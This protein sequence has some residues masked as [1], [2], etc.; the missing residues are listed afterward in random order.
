MSLIKQLLEVQLIS[1]ASKDKGWADGYS[2][3]NK[4]LSI[5]PNEY[6]LPFVASG[7]LPGGRWALI[8]N[9]KSK[10]TQTIQSRKSLKT[11]LKCGMT[12]S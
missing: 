8:D 7:K 1:I 5:D 10:R 11:N 3:V 6:D 4:T 2:M 12:I 9:K